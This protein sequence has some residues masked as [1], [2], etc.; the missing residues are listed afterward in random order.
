MDT[1]KCT[2]LM[3]APTTLKQWLGSLTASPVT[4][5]SVISYSLEEN[6]LHLARSPHSQYHNAA[7]Y[8]L[9]SHFFLRFVSIS[10]V[11]HVCFVAGTKCG[12][13]YFCVTSW[14]LTRSHN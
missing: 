11:A 1:Q 6:G 3:K 5:G 4:S 12:F 8:E 13:V 9:N 10:P 7:R 14:N 2:Q